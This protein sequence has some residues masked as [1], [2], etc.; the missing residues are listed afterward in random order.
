MWKRWLALKT[1]LLSHAGI[2]RY[3]ANTAWLMGEKLLRMFIGLFV[4]IWVA[5]YLGPEQFGLLSYAQSFVF[6]FTAIATLGLDS[7]VVRELVRDNSQQQVLLGTSFALKLIGSLCILPL[8][9][10]GVQFTSND[11]YTNL[12]IFIIASGTIFQSFNVIDF[13]YQSRVMSKYVAFANTLTLAVSSI[14]KIALILNQASLVAFALVGVFDTIILA[15]GLIYFYIHKTQHSIRHW[16]F[17][18]VVAKRLVSDSWPLILASM[19][20][21]VQARIDQVM[22]KDMI[23][24]QEVGYYSAGMRLIEAFGFIPV[25]LMQS[26]YPAIQNAK[27]TSTRLYHKRLLNFYRLNFAL[28]LVVAIPLY[29][30]AEAI[31]S[32]L[33]G[34][35]FKRVG[36]IL[37]LLSTRLFFANMGTARDAF[38][39]SEN[40]FKYAMVAMIIGTITNVMANYWLIPIYQ[41]E[42]AIIATIISFSVTTFIVDYIYNKTRVNVMLQLRAMFSFYKINK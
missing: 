14:I 10:L 9:W 32:L 39:I 13:Y 42:G 34:E 38:I 26:L 3:G 28:F 29:L 16:Q 21:T 30:F 5:R 31:V 41:S 15:L 4:G 37:S 8:L 35:E 33:Y 22:L 11:S 6:L 19:V 1:Q 36:G 17:D 12:L 7:I 27:S 20:V 24:N 18:R 23:G 40:L 2:R 25:V